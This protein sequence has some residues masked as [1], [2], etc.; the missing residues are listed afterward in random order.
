MKRR[1][2]E[3][4]QADALLTEWAAGF[5]AALGMGY[6]PQS[7]EPTVQ[8][9]RSD[10]T[11]PERYASKLRRHEQLDRAVR[12]VADTDPV[13]VGVLRTKYL[14]G[15]VDERIMA[16]EHGVSLRTWRRWRNAARLAFLREYESIYQ[17]A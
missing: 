16:E 1:P 6:I 9:Q 14:G 13:F 12:R 17:A 5:E 15:R 10:W 11:S 2:T 4:D 7:M 8:T 3:Q